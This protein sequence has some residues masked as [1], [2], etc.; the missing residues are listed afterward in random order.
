MTFLLYRYGAPKIKDKSCIQFLNFVT[1]IHLCQ[2]NVDFIF[3]TSFIRVCIH[4]STF[5]FWLLVFFQRLQERYSSARIHARLNTPGSTFETPETDP[6]GGASK[7][8]YDPAQPTPDQTP[9]GTSTAATSSSGVDPTKPT[10]SLDK[11]MAKHTSEDNESFSD[12][13]DEEYKVYRK[14]DAHYFCNHGRRRSSAFL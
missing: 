10:E 11:F 7:E 12:L 3:T 5:H 2:T 1:Q 13:M 4:Q 8:D 14:V 6:T 9:G